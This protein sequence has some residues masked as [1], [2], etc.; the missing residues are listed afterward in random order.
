MIF[1]VIYKNT[2][3]QTVVRR[4]DCEEN[5]LSK[6]VY[7]LDDIAAQQNKLVRIDI[8][9]ELLSLYQQGRLDALGDTVPEDPNSDN[10]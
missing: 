10:E 8:E 4:V 3:N 5:A 7:N 6:L 2:Q 1:R 9:T